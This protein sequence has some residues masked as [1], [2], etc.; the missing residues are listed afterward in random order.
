MS[1]RP[2]I[3]RQWKTENTHSF[4]CTLLDMNDVNINYTVGKVA[5]DFASSVQ[6]IWDS[7]SSVTGCNVAGFRIGAGF[8]SCPHAHCT[9][10]LA[11]R[12]LQD[13]SCM[14]FLLPCLFSFS[15]FV[16]SLL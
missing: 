8:S 6:K 2:L 11:S 14:G 9:T 13:R 1:A 16:F 3:V 4:L 10:G 5:N 7:S 15:F 12:F